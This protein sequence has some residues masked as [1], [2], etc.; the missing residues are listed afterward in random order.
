MT[1]KRDKKINL[2]RFSGIAIL[3]L[4]FI[5]A[6][7][8]GCVSADSVSTGD[9]FANKIHTFATGSA[10]ELTLDLSS[11]VELS[12]DN[13]NVVVASCSMAYMVYAKEKTLTI[14]FNGHTLKAKYDGKDISLSGTEP[15]NLIRSNDGGNTWYTTISCSGTLSGEI[16]GFIKVS[17]IKVTDAKVTQISGQNEGE[18]A[19]I[20][21]KS[22]GGT[23]TI[24]GSTYAMKSIT[25]PNQPLTLQPAPGA[26]KKSGSVTVSSDKFTGKLV[27]N[28]G[29]EVEV[30]NGD[31]EFKAEYKNGASARLSP[32]S[33]TV[34]FT[35]DGKSGEM[36]LSN[37]AANYASAGLS[38]S[39]DVKVNSEVWLSQPLPIP[40]FVKPV[41]FYLN[42]K[43][44]HTEADKV[45]N[46]ESG[47]DKVTVYNAGY[48]KGDKIGTDWPSQF[49]IV[50]Q[51]TDITSGIWHLYYPQHHG[52]G[53][54]GSSGSSEV[55]QWSPAPQP[56]VT[57]VTTADILDVENPDG[58]KADVT[59]SDVSSS[60]SNVLF[61][62]ATETEMETGII[63]SGVSAALAA[64][65]QITN[66]K[67]Y[68][69]LITTAN[70]VNQVQFAKVF[71]IVPAEGA[72]IGEME[73]SFSVPLADISAKGLTTDDVVLYHGLEEYG[74]WVPLNTM[75]V[76]TDDTEAY[77]I[78]ITDGASPFGVLIAKAPE[79]ASEPATQ[80]PAS[81][82]PFAGILAGL[83]AA[84]F[85]GA[86]LRRK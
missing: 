40:K 72:E 70:A 48:F 22:T 84:V 75:L 7:C 16:S 11:D 71:E 66:D 57:P 37:V 9:E 52:G 5:A 17:G 49:K 80:T 12:S 45:F 64:G 32:S 23:L 30:T 74:I 61:R 73:I 55:S 77:Y 76:G 10:T 24:A 43:T 35:S 47:A 28:D 53:G 59:V 50:D 39:G 60:Y 62:A 67:G 85:A 19:H 18:N 2:R 38:M 36:A 13:L 21:F 86:A 69:V 20:D 78:A 42:D 27:L 41:K 26:D 3:S 4:I 46:Y 79:S 8:V 56:P 82:M 44:V 58:T 68:P 6:V 29:S 34:T 15:L 54:G 63:S 51:S 25:I 81:P 31:F 33:A 14:K 65:V 1:V 83:G